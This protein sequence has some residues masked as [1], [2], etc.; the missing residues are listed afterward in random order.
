MSDLELAA[1]S[2]LTFEQRL[3]YWQNNPDALDD[4]IARWKKKQE[5]EGRCRR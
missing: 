1:Y 2:M 3:A 4:A 5:R